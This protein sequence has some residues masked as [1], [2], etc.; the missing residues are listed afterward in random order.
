MARLVRTFGAEEQNC[1]ERD[2]WTVHQ[3]LS[4]AHVFNHFNLQMK[5]AGEYWH[6][7]P[8][9]LNEIA[10]LACAPFLMY[11]IY[12]YIMYIYVRILWSFGSL[13]PCS[14]RWFFGS[15]GFIQWC[16]WGDPGWM[17]IPPLGEYLFILKSEFYM[18]HHVTLCIYIY[19]IWYHIPIIS[20]SFIA[21]PW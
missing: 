20:P 4:K 17:L 2:L 19:I 21:I 12:I 13:Q 3:S 1:G 14:C 15:L 11:I 16:T 18:S 9:F 8:F 7:C 5:L 10:H 6:F